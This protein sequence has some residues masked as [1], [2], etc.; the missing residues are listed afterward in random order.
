[1][2]VN[3]ITQ[4]LLTNLYEIFLRNG[5]SESIWTNRL[6]VVIRILIQIEK[7]LKGIYH[8]DIGSGKLKDPHRGSRKPE[9]MQARPRTEQ[10][11]TCPGG[12]LSSPNGSGY[13][14]YLLKR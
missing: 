14:C 3:R 2:S 12:G 1:L 9:Y 6:P 10:F 8:C 13:Y 4:K 5:W 11:K 7:F